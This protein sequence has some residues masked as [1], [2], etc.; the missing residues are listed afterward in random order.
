MSVPA[1]AS[2]GKHAG[3]V[4]WKTFTDKHISYHASDQYHWGWKEFV[5]I[6]KNN[7][8]K[9]SK[10]VINMPACKKN[11]TTGANNYECSLVCPHIWM[12][13]NSSLWWLIYFITF[14]FASIYKYLPSLIYHST[15]KTSDV[16]KQPKTALRQDEDSSKRTINQLAFMTCLWVPSR[17][18]STVVL[19]ATHSPDTTG[20]HLFVCR[21]LHTPFLFHNLSYFSFFSLMV[22]TGQL[23]L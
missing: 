21:S 4:C 11:E 16:L 22:C 17:Q 8:I 23:S 14:K 19:N 1:A 7:K 2:Q 5:L 18:S 10:K 12:E 20:I 6:K 15:L 3:M 9:I 13:N